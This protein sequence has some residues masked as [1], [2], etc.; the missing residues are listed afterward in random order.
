MLVVLGQDH[1]AHLSFLTTIASEGWRFHS[2]LAHTYANTG[3]P[4][5]SEFARIAVDF[6]TKGANAKVYQSAA[7]TCM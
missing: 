5:V 6:L 4:V 3:M 7:S 2:E 1:R